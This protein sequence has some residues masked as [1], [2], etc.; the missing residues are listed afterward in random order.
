MEECKYGF[1]TEETIRVRKSIRTYEG[2]PLSSEDKKKMVSF[3]EQS[4]NP[5]EQKLQIRLI[6]TNAAAKGE[7]L[8]T[9]GVIKGASEFI[10]VTVKNSAT[11]LEAVGY[12]VEQLI[13]YATSLGLGTCWLGGTFQRGSFASAMNIKEDEILPIISPIGY[14]AEKKRTSEKLMLMLGQSANRAEFSEHFFDGH[15][16]MPLTKAT[17]GDFFLPLEM[18][19][20]APSAMN[21]QPWR[22]IKN[23]NRIDFYLQEGIMSKTSPV[24]LSKVDIGIAACHFDL[25]RKEMGISGQ[26]RIDEGSADL[27]ERKLKYEFS[28]FAE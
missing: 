23:G 18:V 26:F 4:S 1:A 8:G 27:S 9:Y 12:Q 13:L 15:F 20:L 25:M 11:A 24:K 16:H 2:R 14:P 17:A 3:I 6:Q 21:K 7:K 19:R 28:F 10:G 22:I 5:F